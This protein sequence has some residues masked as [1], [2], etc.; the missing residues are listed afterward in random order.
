[1]RPKH[2]RCF[3]SIVVE[4]AILFPCDNICQIPRCLLKASAFGL[5]FREHPRDLAKVINKTMFH[6]YNGSD[7]NTI[8]CRRNLFCKNVYIY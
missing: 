4:Y 6:L 2:V 3:F 7:A 5:G 8:L 1:M